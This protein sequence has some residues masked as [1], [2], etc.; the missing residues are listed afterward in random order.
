MG[1]RN[2]VLVTRN[3]E[4][5]NLTS[6]EFV[7]MMFNDVHEAVDKYDDMYMPE[8]V[9]KK[10]KFVN[11]RIAVTERCAKA[12]AEKKWKTEKKRIEYVTKEVCATRKMMSDRFSRYYCGITFFDFDVNPGSNGLSRNCCFSLSTLTPEALVR[13]FNEV[14]DNKYFKA[15]HG[16]TLEYEAS[17][18]SYRN[19]FR[20]QVKLIVDTDVEAQMKADAKALADS[21]AGFY[22]NCS[23]SVD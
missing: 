11:D 22:R 12:Y 21:I 4:C 14:K 5:G 2:I 8:H 19:L 13:C 3:T 1:Y 20:P 16:W 9:E 10:I 23:Y 7:K 18:N 17:E 15:A 6:E